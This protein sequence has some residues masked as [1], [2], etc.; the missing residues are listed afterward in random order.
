MAA[1]SNGEG[2]KALAACDSWW[3]AKTT[4]ARQAGPRA[5]RIASRI[6]SFVPVQAATVRRKAA[7]P[8]GA[9]PSIVS[10]CRSSLTSGFS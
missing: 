3:V 4:R 5:C 8:R 1:S 2:K 9:N 6:R 10:S 7:K